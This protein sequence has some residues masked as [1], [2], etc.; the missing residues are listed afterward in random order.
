MSGSTGELSRKILR[1]KKNRHFTFCETKNVGVKRIDILPS[2]VKEERVTNPTNHYYLYGVD[3]I[4]TGSLPWK[5]L[6]ISIKRTT[7]IM[8][9][10]FREFLVQDLIRLFYIFHNKV[11]N[12]VFMHTIFIT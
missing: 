1:S 7:Y 5:V 12:F 2:L 8:C 6:V 11:K 10:L 4:F 9:G 3:C